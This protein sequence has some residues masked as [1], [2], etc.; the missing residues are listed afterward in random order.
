MPQ[1]S[2]ISLKKIKGK[3]HMINMLKK[4]QKYG[5]IILIICMFTLTSN[6]T[7]AG[8]S[9]HSRLVTGGG[10]TV[11]TKTV[12]NQEI[13]IETDKSVEI[14]STVENNKHSID[15]K[16]HETPLEK[17]DCDMIKNNYDL[18]K[19]LIMVWISCMTKNMMI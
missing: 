6:V 7:L 2:N 19:I 18:I 17:K 10:K 3:K 14:V 4:Y 11:F 16:E 12:N 8:T 1:S 5:I 15:V 9:I 13:K